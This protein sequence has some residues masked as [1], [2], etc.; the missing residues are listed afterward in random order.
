MET[1]RGRSLPFSHTCL[2]MG[3]TPL[4]FLIN[5]YVI[6]NSWFNVFYLNQ[7]ISNIFALMKNVFANKTSN[8]L[9]IK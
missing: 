3:D 7:V 6:Q 5:N 4:N 8:C 2:G 1:K 9:E